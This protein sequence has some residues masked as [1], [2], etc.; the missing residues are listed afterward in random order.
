MMLATL[1]MKVR[2]GRGK[3]GGELLLLTVVWVV[4]ELW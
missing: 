3:L 4:S 2:L 1:L